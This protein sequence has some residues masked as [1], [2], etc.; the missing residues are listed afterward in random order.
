MSDDHSAKVGVIPNVPCAS[1][2]DPN[3][4]E[5]P[6]ASSWYFTVLDGIA[7]TTRSNRLEIRV[8]LAV[9]LLNSNKSAFH[10]SLAV[11]APQINIPPQ[12]HA[13]V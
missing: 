10:R 13:R 5:T 4:I 3:V 2:D 8:G 7:I 1:K 9:G 11:Y 6:Q 12:S